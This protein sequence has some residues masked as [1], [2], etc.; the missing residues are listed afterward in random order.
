M[1][2][3][4]SLVHI[5]KAFGKLLHCSLTRLSGN[6]NR[7]FITNKINVKHRR[8]ERI[9][10]TLPGKENQ[11]YKWLIRK[12][13]FL[14]Q[15]A[16]TTAINVIQCSFFVLVNTLSSTILCPLSSSSYCCYTTSTAHFFLNGHWFGVEIIQMVNHL[17]C[18][19]IAPPLSG[20]TTFA[21]R[22]LWLILSRFIMRPNKLHSSFVN[23]K[24]TMTFF[25]WKSFR[26][27][28]KMEDFF[29][30]VCCDGDS[31]YL[32]RGKWWNASCAVKNPKDHNDRSCDSAFQ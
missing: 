17:W 26:N 8:L 5:R 7:V 20:A 31:F 10:V 16:M 13:M 30:T 2:L 23:L 1:W 29:F 3:R 15:K 25:C 4:H 27:H 19:S 32:N 21:S 12:Q 18:A 28:V 24:T 6:Y 9:T 22:L 11:K 14:L